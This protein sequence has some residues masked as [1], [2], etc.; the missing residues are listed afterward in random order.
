MRI[1]IGGEFD[2]NPDLIN[3]FEQFDLSLNNFLF[4]SGRVALMKILK[5]NKT[6]TKTK[7]IIYLPYYVC[8][9]V[10]EAC[11]KQKYS[12]KFYEID[13]NFLFD[14]NQIQKIKMNSTLLTLN[15]FGF[16]NDNYILE[17]V[18]N[19]RPDIT[20]ISDN[21]QSL[22]QCHKSIADFSFTSL[23]KCLPV[24][25]GALIYCKGILL[26]PEKNVI[27]NEFYKFKLLGSISKYNNQNDKIYLNYFE[28]GEKLLAEEKK[29]TK[30]CRFSEY[31]YQNFDFEKYN[32]IRE[33]NYTNVYKLGSQIGL[34]FIFPYSKGIKPLCIPILLKNRDEVRKR[35]F[36]RNIFLPVHWSLNQY[37]YKSEFSNKMA[38]NELSLL[39]DH[40]YSI[41]EIE[42]Q[43]NELKK[44]I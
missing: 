20:T 3:G 27:E 42:Y 19:I 32:K 1:K 15:Y 38:N 31:T 18:K 29:I 2:I 16:V 41:N 17:K 11:K 24:P 28:K 8:S 22:Q 5:I 39:I 10:I 30:A 35:L 37:N 36:K 7:L 26:K 4:S 12:I 33:E 25:D 9:S 43:L 14:I 40:R 23:R 6:K 13:E 34:N 44:L 21:V